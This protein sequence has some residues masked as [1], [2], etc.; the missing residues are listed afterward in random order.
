[1]AY[2]RE[3]EDPQATLAAAVGFA[4]TSTNLDQRDSACKYIGKLLENNCGATVEY[5]PTGGAPAISATI[6]GTST[7][8]ILFYGHYDV[9]DPGARTDWNSDPFQLT[10]R[11]GRLFGR[12]TGD[13]KGQ[14][15]AVI[16]GLNR[17]LV[18]H[19]DHQ[20]T[21]QLLIEGEEEQGSVHLA[22]T[23]QKLRDKQ[24]CN[25]RQV[26]VVDGSMSASGDHVLRLANR[27]LF[28][29]KL[30][31]TTATHANHSG[32][33]GNVLDNPVLIFQRI[34]DHLYDPE[35]GQVLIPG[36][37]TGV[38]EPTASDWAAIDR[39]PFDAEQTERVFGGSLLTKDKR[40]Y[41]RRLMF[42]P[43]FNV[44]GIES[45]YNGA[46]IKTIIPGDLTASINMRLVGHQNPANIAANLADVLAPFVAA[47][48]LT[49][50]STGDI[51]PATTKATPDEITVFQNAARRAGVQLLIEPC[52][53]GTVPNY[54]W[55]D[56]LGVQTFTLPL[57]NFDQN[58][59]SNN[60]N[61]TKA[62]FQQGIDLIEALAT[63]YE[64]NRS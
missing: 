11:E 42:Q 36:F 33:A 48:V 56:I 2:I 1:M 25:V 64:N 3:I 40:E 22:A 45:G 26:V 16:N 46:G 7:D 28:G 60:E 54:V 29:I 59:H 34:L 24:L 27:G 30:H 62:A 58:N 53:P 37:Y 21:I 38:E 13:N 6:P 23:V 41:Y 19:P 43:S 47:G 12:G 32:N 15:L 50:E 9:M 55:T 20:Q 63:E 10:V 8:T 5:V 4:S 51:P 44:S 17:F 18:A 52:M 35:D 31:I 61:I 14:L 39:L 49:Y 57:A